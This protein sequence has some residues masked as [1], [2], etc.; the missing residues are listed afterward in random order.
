MGVKA[1]RGDEGG[2]WKAE[3]VEDEAEV[4]LRW[5]GRNEG[6]AGQR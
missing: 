1:G 4:G 6:G 5:R 2:G 3:R